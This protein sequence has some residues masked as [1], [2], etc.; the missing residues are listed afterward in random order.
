MFL[1]GW[2]S[3]PQASRSHRVSRGRRRGLLARAITSL[4]KEAARLS[5]QTR[6]SR[7]LGHVTRCG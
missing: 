2:L 1:L 3:P 4:V 7:G 6:A 5:F